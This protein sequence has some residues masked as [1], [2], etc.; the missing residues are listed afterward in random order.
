MFLHEVQLREQGSCETD[1]VV[2]IAQDGLCDIE[3]VEPA[4]EARP[5]GGQLVLAQKLAEL[6]NFLGDLAQRAFFC[7]REVECHRALL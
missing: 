5:V 3:K 2:E 4:I 7:A 6:A 1:V